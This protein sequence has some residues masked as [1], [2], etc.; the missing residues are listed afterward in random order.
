MEATRWTRRVLR[1]FSLNLR[2][3]SPL[4]ELTRFFTPVTWTFQNLH[5]TRARPATSAPCEHF[6]SANFQH[7]ISNPRQARFPHQ[8]QSLTLAAQPWLKIPSRAKT[9]EGLASAR[10]EDRARSRNPT[11]PTLRPWLLPSL[12]LQAGPEPSPSS[13]IRC[14]PGRKAPRRPSRPVS[15]TSSL[16]EGTP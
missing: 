6:T 13:S 8:L 10:P 9:A 12:R 7:I 15:S 1:F 14:S 11:V 4:L 5:L 16:S 2:L 3:R